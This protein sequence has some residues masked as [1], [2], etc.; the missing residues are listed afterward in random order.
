MSVSCSIIPSSFS[1]LAGNLLALLGRQFLSPG[2]P[3]L[4]SSEASESDG[5]GVLLFG[6][7]FGMIISRSLPRGFG[8]DLEGKLV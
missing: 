5:G 3:A 1:G 8:H 6:G 4:Q 7:R 2:R